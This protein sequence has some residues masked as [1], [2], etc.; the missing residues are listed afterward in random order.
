MKAPLF[1][2]DDLGGNVA[3]STDVTRLGPEMLLTTL[4]LEVREPLAKVFGTIPL[5]RPCDVCRAEPRRC[6]DEEPWR[7]RHSAINRLV[8][9]C[10]SPVKMRRRYF[11]I[12]TKW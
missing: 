6:G 7:S 5:E 3:R 2:A 11:G 1:P 8:S 9:G 10:T 4:L 12:Q